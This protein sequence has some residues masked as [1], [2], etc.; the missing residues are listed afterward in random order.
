VSDPLSNRRAGSAV[1]APAH[2]VVFLLA[3]LALSIFGAMR[4]PMAAW[5]QE[6]SIP[7]ARSLLYVRIIALQLVWVAYVW[8]GVRRR[9]GTVRALLDNSPLTAR[10]WLRYVLVGLA[11]LVFWLVVSAGLGTI[12]RPSEAHLRG[13]Q[14][15]LPHT[16]AERLLWVAFALSAAICEEIVY[17]GYLFRQFRAA[18]SRTLVALVLQAATYAAAHLVLPVEMVVSVGLLGLLLGAIAV[19]QKSLVPAMIL[20]TGTGLM[21][22]LASGP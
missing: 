6:L 7:G 18:S 3:M 21:A 19:W 8:F 17:R 15:M 11:A 12:L 14:S 13:L 20:H 22:I 10:R 5:S 9:G 4:S 2:T 16:A 1:A